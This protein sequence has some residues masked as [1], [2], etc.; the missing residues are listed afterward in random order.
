MIK[1]Y[2]SL[3]RKKE[4]FVPITPVSVKI[5]ACGITPY[6]SPHLGHLTSVIRWNILRRFLVYSGYNVIFVQNVTDIDDKIINRAKEKNEDPFRLSSFYNDEFVSISKDLDLVPDHQPKVSEYI[7]QIIKYIQKI[8]QNKCAY[9]TKNGDVYFDVKSIE[10]YGILSNRKVS[11]QEEG[12]RETSRKID[13]EDKRNIYDFAL[14]KRFE[15]LTGTFDSPWGRGRPGW[16]IECSTLVYEL[17]GEKFDIHCGGLDLLFPH[18]ENEIAQCKAHSCSPNINHKDLANNQPLDSVFAKYWVHTGLLSVNG[19]KMS[20]SLNNFITAKDAIEKYGQSLIIYTTLKFHYR[21]QINFSDQLFFENLNQITDIYW[22]IEELASLFKHIQY[23]NLELNLDLK[24]NKINDK[25]NTTLSNDLNTP[26]AIVEILNLTNEAKKLYKKYSQKKEDVDLKIL[27]TLYSEI[28]IASTLLLFYKEYIPY[29]Q[30]VNETLKFALNLR[31][32]KI[33][34][35]D[36]LI[37]KLEER[38]LG[39]E[40]KDFAKADKVR[41]EMLGFNIEIM[42]GDQKGWRFKSL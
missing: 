31:E 2:N 9:I 37:S 25:I 18:H 28:K 30:I 19:V 3:S 26:E 5:Y 33:L 13:K 4:N 23:E 41:D 35:Y 21:S 27:Y 11:E 40:Q 15:E 10:Q 32:L 8:V 20:K 22:I 34:D 17:L 14:W 6:D 12:T 29:K 38:R 36:G 39:R 16:H 42:D 24:A 7:P 1:L